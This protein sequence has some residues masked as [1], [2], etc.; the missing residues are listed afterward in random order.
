MIKIYHN[1][2][3][4]M[5]LTEHEVSELLRSKISEVEVEISEFTNGPITWTDSGRAE[6]VKTAE[7]IRS[8][9]KDIQD[10][11]KRFDRE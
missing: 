5:E 11:I 6:L 3:K 4:T 8:L 1:D 7:T 2:R 10:T 9:L